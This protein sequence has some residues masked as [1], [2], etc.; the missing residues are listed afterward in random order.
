[1]ENLPERVC[2]ECEVPIKL[3]ITRD[4]TRKFFCGRSCRNRFNGR[5]RDLSKFIAAGQTV[6]ANAKKGRKGEANARWKPIGS[7]VKAHSGYIKIKLPNGK[8]EYE[9]R[10]I[11]CAP[12][13]LHV[14]HVDENTSNNSFENLRLVTN[15]EHARLHNTIEGWALKYSCCKK[16]STSSRKHVALGLCTACYQYERYHHAE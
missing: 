12:K 1:M 6:E 2:K 5:L 8:Y 16:C 13:E 15:S 11:A 3:K 4:L 7:R 14:H 10:I 9:H